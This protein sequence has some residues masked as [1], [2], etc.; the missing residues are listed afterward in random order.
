MPL[1]LNQ[2]RPDPIDSEVT[3]AMM[4]SLMMQG[5]GDN[6]GRFHATLERFKKALEAGGHGGRGQ[7]T[8]GVLLACAATLLGDE[9]AAEMG[10][11]LGPDEEREWSKLLAA[12]NLPEVED[13]KPNYRQCVDQI[14]TA[15]VKSWRNSSRNTIGQTIEELRTVDDA[16]NTIEAPIDRGTAKRDL[17]IAGFGLFNARELV[18]GVMRTEKITLAAA[19]TRYGLPEAG[20]ILAVPNKSSKVAEHL[21]GSDWQHGAWKDALRQCPVPGVMITDADI[22]RVSIDGTQTRCTLIVLDRYREAPEK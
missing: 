7:D 21:V 9:L 15:V 4:L 20:W 10:V 14:L 16:G 11:P 19:L 2:Q 1:N 12:E 18:A 13:A 17:N 3:G 6:G 8:Y 22:N 5:W